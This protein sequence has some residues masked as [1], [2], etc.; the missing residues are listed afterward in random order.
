MLKTTL[1]DARRWR[2]ILNAISTLQEEAEFKVSPEGLQLRAMDTSHTT[3]IDLYLPRVFFDQYECD[4]PTEL[5][6]NVKNI[7]NL[8][9]GVGPNETIEINYEEEQ[10]KCVIY[11]KGEYQRIFNLT[12]LAIEGE[13]VP[14]LRATFD[15]RAQVQTA[16]FKKI[17]NESQKIGDRICIEAKADTI[18]FRTVGL[19]GSVV[20]AFKRGE[21][22]LVELNIDHESE[23]TY[24]LDLL[25]PVIKN[26]STISEVLNIE[27]STGNPLRVDLIMLHGKLHFYLSPMMEES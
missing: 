3:M 12:T 15:V 22:P 21:A 27:Y 18:T 7:L 14:E 2:D 4:K 24:S 25:G 23:A 10:A 6:L 1:Y 17:I 9:E 11:L 5:R 8:L 20:S 16:S 26:A 19:I 13:F